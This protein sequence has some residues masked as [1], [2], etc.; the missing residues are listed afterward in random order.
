VV[1]AAAKE[2]RLIATNGMQTKKLFAIETIDIMNPAS[3]L[4]TAAKAHRPPV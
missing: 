2:I 1:P 3:M 4:F